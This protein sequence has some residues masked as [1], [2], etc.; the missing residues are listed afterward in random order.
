[1]KILRREVKENY[2]T[3]NRNKNYQAARK[4]IAQLSQDLWS[5]IKPRIH[6]IRKTIHSQ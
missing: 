4:S 6:K 5:I 1:M 2:L 3:S